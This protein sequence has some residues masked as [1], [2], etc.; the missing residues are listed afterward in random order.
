[1]KKILLQY[2]SLL[3]IKFSAAM[4]ASSAKLDNV[5]GSSNH[6]VSSDKSFPEKMN[7]PF[8]RFV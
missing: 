3:S 5:S 1:M 6:F 4:V 8:L 2:L 7:F